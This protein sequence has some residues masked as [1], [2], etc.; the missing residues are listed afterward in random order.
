MDLKIVDGKGADLKPGEIGEIVGRGPML[1]TEYYKNPEQTKETMKDGW[2]FTGD[3][4]YVDKDGFLFLTGRKKDL[5][6]SGGV[7]VY[8]TDIE[9]VVI[10]HPAVKDVAVFGVPHE[11]W[12][13]TPVAAVV[14]NE[15]IAATPIEIK[16]W[17]NQNLEA[18]YQKIYKV[19]I[20]YELPRN[21]A[22]KILKRELRDKFSD[23]KNNLPGKDIKTLKMKNCFINSNN[24]KLHYLEF[25][26]EQP[27]IIFMHGLTANAHSF[28]GL[29]A[30][31]L[32]SAFNI[33]SVDLRG[34]G[35][36]D[37][38]D[39]GYTMKEHA[40]DIIGLMDA[41]KIE[42]VIL[43][44]HSFGGFLALYLAKFFPARVDKLILM[45]AAANMHPNT[46]DMLTPALSRL[47]QNFPS[48]NAYIE[49]VKAAPYLTFWDEQML[50]YYK[51]DVKTNA[52]G[53]VSCIPQPAHMM[54]AVLKGSLGEPWL[55]YLRSVE[56]QAILINAPGIYTMEAA[57]LPE[58]NAIETVE[59]MKNCIYAKVPGNH[60]TMLYGDGAKEIVSI[61]KHFI[62]Q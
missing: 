15:G 16:C 36:S 17:A 21:V 33:L 59:L 39:S 13:E 14:L 25:E 2:L 30:A 51:A 7:N 34:R 62:N 46:K 10:R 19:I 47:G 18:R 8:P 6:I 32:S 28:D 11:E 60:Q 54:E 38:P 61:I 12:G 24:I 31:G 56:Q 41:L 22:G 1:M 29:I 43:A 49:K 52:D 57:L 27:T 20:M 40:D 4:G 26:G 48:F 37:A 35:E 53:T 50:S 5:I 3:L 58:E 55:D 9:E 45:D 42:K 44:G 23:E